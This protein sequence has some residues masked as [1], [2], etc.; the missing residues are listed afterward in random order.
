MPHLVA[1]A[2]KATVPGHVS[3]SREI[4]VFGLSVGIL[5]VE[6]DDAGLVQ[7]QW[8]SVRELL[9]PT[10]VTVLGLD[11]LALWVVGRAL[12]HY[13]AGGRTARADA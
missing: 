10:A 5:R 9:A 2:L 4:K 7:H 11:L 12:R 6:S 8:R 1:R 3:L 13:T